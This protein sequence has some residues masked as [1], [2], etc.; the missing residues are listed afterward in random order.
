M[1]DKDDLIRYEI[2]YP[3][4]LCGSKNYKCFHFDGIVTIMKCKDCGRFEEE[5]YSRNNIQHWSD[6]SEGVYFCPYDKRYPYF[7]LTKNG[8]IIKIKKGLFDKDCKR[9]IFDTPQDIV[10]KHYKTKIVEY[11]KETKRLD[12]LYKNVK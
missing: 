8:N 5:N 9:I 3:E 10:K 12:R 6:C 11:K 1:N 2:D 7:K 4:C